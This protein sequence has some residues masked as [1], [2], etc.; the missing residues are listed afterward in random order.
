MSSKS[1]HKDLSKLQNKK[2]DYSGSA[3]CGSFSFHALL[4]N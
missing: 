3:S 2:S 1:E 4:A